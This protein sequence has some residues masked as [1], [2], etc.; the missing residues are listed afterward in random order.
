MGLQRVGVLIRKREFYH[1]PP[2][3]VEFARELW[4]SGV[5]NEDIAVKVNEKFSGGRANS[6]L[7]SGWSDKHNWRKTA[8]VLEEKA[9]QKTTD[10]L[11]EIL[12][13]Q[14][15][16]HLLS[17][18]LLEQ[19]GKAALEG[20]EVKVRTAGEALDLVDKGIKG[21]RTIVS[22]AL[23]MEFVMD[24]A[25]V[26]KEEITDLVLVNRVAQRLAEVVIKYKSRE[27]SRSG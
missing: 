6:K 21:Q 12:S 22:N 26:I 23:Q 20:D 18:K 10:K 14:D 3:V 27:E 8:V 1:Y 19:K 25:K 5:P 4:L 7:I 15:I 17:Y 11:A 24:V 16:E 2:K 9:L 13:N